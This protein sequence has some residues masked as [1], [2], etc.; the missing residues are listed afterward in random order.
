MYEFLF[1]LLDGGQEYP[2]R[3]YEL[4]DGTCSISSMLV[5]RGT[6]ALHCWGL[7]VDEAGQPYLN[8]DRGSSYMVF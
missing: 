1:R 2:V 6:I 3:S 4:A 8:T 7:Q 5:G